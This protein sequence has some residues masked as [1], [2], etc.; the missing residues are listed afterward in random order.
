[1]REEVAW[2][3][4]IWKIVKL[5]GFCGQRHLHHG[6]GCCALTGTW[7]LRKDKVFSAKEGTRSLKKA[8]CAKLLP[9]QS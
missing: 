5:L 1:M 8:K 6:T 4:I 7:A 9:A 3:A 2:D